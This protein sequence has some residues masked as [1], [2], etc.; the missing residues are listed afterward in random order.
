VLRY[1]AKYVHPIGASQKTELILG[2]EPFFDL[3]DTDWGGDAGLGSLRSTIGVGWKV[4]PKLGIEAGYMNQY[5]F[6]DN[7]EDLDN[8]LGVV[9]FKVKF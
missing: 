7:G 9:N 3:V 5:I 2:V 4:S 8:H 6:N 1:M